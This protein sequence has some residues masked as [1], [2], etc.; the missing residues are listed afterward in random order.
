MKALTELIVFGGASVAIH[1]AVVNGLQISEAGSDGAGAAGASAITL[2][3]ATPSLTARVEEWT[4]PPT[5]A[6]TTAEPRRPD[7]ERLEPIA[8]D[9]AD[10]PVSASPGQAAL[11]A[12]VLPDRRAASVA[13]PPPPPEPPKPV[14]PKPEPVAPEPVPEKAPA[15]AKPEPKTAP[16]RPAEVARGDPAKAGATAGASKPREVAAAA[17]AVSQ[18]AIAD[19]GARIRS[20]IE[21]RK[22]S[23][24]GSWTPGSAVVRITVSREGRLQALGVLKSSG[25]ARLDRAA[26]QAVQ[27]AGRFP[28]APKAFSRPQMT[29][30]LPVSFVR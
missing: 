8:T 18:A 1:L 30:D 23:P 24:G 10:A 5:A 19:W 21:R 2:A 11:A 27:R 16:A 22:T 12:P 9:A 3:A 17:P 4:Q 15:Q 20:R 25:D 14:A 29:F 7:V 6:D 28:A 26:L 13:P